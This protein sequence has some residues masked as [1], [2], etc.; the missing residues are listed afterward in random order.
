[1]GKSLM[2]MLQDRSKKALAKS[3]ASSS[4]HNPPKKNVGSDK[5]P[6][7][8]G[9]DPGKDVVDKSPAKLGG[10]GKDTSGQTPETIGARSGKYMLGKPLPKPKLKAPGSKVMKSNLK[11]PALKRPAA[12]VADQEGG[13]VDADGDGGDD[14]DDDSLQ[15]LQLQPGWLLLQY[16]VFFIVF[17]AFQ[18]FLF[19]IFCQ[20]V[21]VQTKGA[22]PTTK[23]PVGPGVP[24]L[25]RMEKHPFKAIS[26]SYATQQCLWLPSPPCI[27]SISSR[28][29]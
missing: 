2:Q 23:L 27:P 3:K 24:W 20:R 29:N 5:K 28:K 6:E 10:K 17:W 11:Q 25:P 9:H 26:H 8:I 4:S 18:S 1:M 12:S 16:F 21:T 7:K 14:S 19:P 22:L 13:Q 15:V